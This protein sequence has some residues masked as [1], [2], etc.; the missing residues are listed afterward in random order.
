MGS[1]NNRV[2]YELEVD[3][4]LINSELI[5]ELNYESVNELLSDNTIGEKKIC[6]ITEQ[7]KLMKLFIPFYLMKYPPT[8]KDGIALKI[9][10]A[11]DSTVMNLDDEKTKTS[12]A[13]PSKSAENFKTIK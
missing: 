2:D 1:D 7:L 8:S 9:Y 10:E 6:L 5:D 13:L 11:W 12:S 4:T 3:G